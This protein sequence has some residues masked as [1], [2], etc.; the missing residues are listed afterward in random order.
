[1][2]A[3]LALLERARA[4]DL[5]KRKLLGVVNFLEGAHGFRPV[6]ARFLD[7]LDVDK[8]FVVLEEGQTFDEDDIPC[9][10]WVTALL[11]TRL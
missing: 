2:R 6:I 7:V 4:F 10:I 11:Q 1:M 3:G 8:L 9:R 5:E